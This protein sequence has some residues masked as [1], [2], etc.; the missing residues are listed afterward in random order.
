[1]VTAPHTGDKDEGPQHTVST[2][3][4]ALLPHVKYVR[5]TGHRGLK[6]PLKPYAC[7]SAVSPLMAMLKKGHHK[8]SLNRA[9]WRAFAA[10]IDCNA[11]YFGSYDDDMLAGTARE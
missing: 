7:G 1:M 5:V 10:W 4:L 3:F 11:P 6:L 8:V 2:S 9:D